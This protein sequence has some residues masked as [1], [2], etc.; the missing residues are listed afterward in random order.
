MPLFVARR[1]PTDLRSISVREVNDILELG[2]LRPL[3]RDL[4][5]RSPDGTFFHSLEWLECYWRHF[6]ARQRLRVMVVARDGV[7][8]GI[9]PLAVR[10]EPTRVG[11]MSF[12]TWP[13]DYW[14][15]F[16]G[17]L[18]GERQAT[19]E[20]ALAHVRESRHDWQVCELRWCDHD[21]DDSG[22]TEAALA[23]AGLTAYRT[24]FDTTSLVE[25]SGTWAL[26]LGERGSKFRNNFRRWERRLSEHGAIRHVRYRPRGEEFH[27][28]D[29]RWDLYDTCE[30][31]ARQSW[32][33]GSED[34][35]TISSPE[36]RPF[37]REV[38]AAAAAAGGVDLNLLYLG[39]R[40]VAF[41]YNYHHAGRLY[42]LRVGFAPELAKDGAG[43][44]LYLRVIEDSFRRGDT[45]Y[46][47]G[48]GSFE[49]KR[50]LKTSLRTIYRHS[51]YGP[52]PRAQ[53]L[54]LRRRAE[55]ARLHTAEVDRGESH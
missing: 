46:D 2:E 42:S 35:T 16:F 52:N 4:L 36:I 51:H 27:D 18:G 21:G 23:R 33:A 49:A 10:R 17:P 12:L 34:G 53:I 55:S 30:E 48:P 31:I 44:V 22:T 13:L 1:H 38:H 28:G 6:G 20:G 24:N 26:Y 15:S 3:W 8:I 11:P 39:E 9:A 45:F 32:Q 5:S 41:I 50:H 40:P 37:L 25:L 7:P 47:L 29:P 54:R 19:L 14:G 43:N